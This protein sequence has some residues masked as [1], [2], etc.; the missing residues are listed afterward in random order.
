M[1]DIM[2]ALN[3]VPNGKQPKNGFPLESFETFT[4]KGGMLN[5]VGVRDTVPNSD[6]R[7]SV[8]AFTRTLPCNTANF[9]H[10]KEN[11]YFVH[12]PL[13]LINRNAYQML[14]NRKQPFSALDMG[15]SRFPTFSLATVLNRCIEIH[16]MSSS[17][18]I[19]NNFKDVHGFNI[20]TQA[21]RLFDML[22]YGS[23]QDILEADLGLSA[24]AE[25]N[26]KKKAITQLIGNKAPTANRLAAYQMVWYYFFRNDIFDNEVSPRSFNFDD[27]TV[28][29]LT[30]PN[31]DILSV[32]S[33]DDFIRECCQMRYVGYKKDLFTAFM[34]GTQY[35]AVSSVQIGVDI[36]GDLTAQFVGDSQSVQFSGPISATGSTSAT[37]VTSTGTRS[38]VSVSSTG[39]FTPSGT[40]GS[41]D[42]RHSHNAASQNG[43]YANTNSQTSSG[44]VGLYES[45]S[46]SSIV[47]KKDTHT[48]SFTG[49]SATVSVSGSV[50]SQSIS[51]SGTVPSQ[52]VTVS[53]T[54]TFSNVI[55]PSGSVILS[56]GSYSSTSLFD[57]LSLVEAQAIQ[58]WRQ[59]SMLA[60][61]RTADQFRA[62]HGEVPRHLIDHLPDFI[63]SVDNEIQITEITSQAD[64]ATSDD[65]S[66]LGEIAGRGYGASDSRQFHFHS[67]DYGILIL[68]HAIVPENTYSSYG[69]DFGN[70]MVYYNDFY[71]SEFT[72]IG[73]QAIPKFL[74][75]ATENRQGT[76]DKTGS[77]TFNSDVS[78]LGYAPRYFNYK[79]YPSKVHGLFN[80]SR[81]GQYSIGRP[82]RFGFSDMQ[83]FV[84]PRFDMVNNILFNTS[85]QTVVSYGINMTL[86]KLYITPSIFDSIFAINADSSEIT[87]EFITHCKFNC[88]AS[89]PMSVLGLPQF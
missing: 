51:V 86:S 31:Y 7:L 14:V 57:V 34:P 22:G 28:M 8:D 56:G 39:N 53:G 45:G 23:Y 24:S 29:T 49:N 37:S 85:G 41:D 73:L 66:N 69:L 18:L 15:I 6:Y 46:G 43:L 1:R 83:S 72:D 19:T 76:P 4:Q 67:D 87:D 27:V 80:P 60:G 52:S 62:H 5:V 74:L 16:Y 78:I 33:V 59:K 70:T 82:S 21:F 20:G 55:T 75:D 44:Y 17:D 48:H 58:K 71:Q 61:N 42:G 89:L 68:L 65:E 26:L 63:G 13:G 12:V 77:D 64:T 50:P 84:V 54:G 47:L 10:I 40:V 3:R 81:L 79:T 25:I 35:G 88:D 11:Y 36:Q 38:A 32:R 2:Q 30:E 9:A